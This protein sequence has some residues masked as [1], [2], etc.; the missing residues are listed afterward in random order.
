MNPQLHTEMLR[1][2]PALRLS[3]KTVLRLIPAM[4]ISLNFCRPKMGRVPQSIASESP[5]VRGLQASRFHAR[6]G[7]RPERVEPPVPG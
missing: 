7:D 4:G 3:K 1:P 6:R 2:L 5:G